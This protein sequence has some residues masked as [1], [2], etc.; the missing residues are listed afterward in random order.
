[1][2]NG[3]SNSSLTEISIP[4]LI[5]RRKNLGMSLRELSRRL[6]VD[7]AGVWRWEAGKVMPHALFLRAWL[8]T[9][10]EAEKAAQTA[11]VASEEE[12]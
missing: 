9:I 3:T 11:S 12:A 4:E 1:M 2:E 7:V 5:E 6:G 10:K 8:E